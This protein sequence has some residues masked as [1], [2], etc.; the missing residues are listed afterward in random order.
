MWPLDTWGN[1]GHHSPGIILSYWVMEMFMPRRRIHVTERVLL[2]TTGTILSMDQNQWN[3][4]GVHGLINHINPQQVKMRGHQNQQQHFAYLWDILCVRAPC[5]SRQS[6]KEKA[7]HVPRRNASDTC[8]FRATPWPQSYTRHIPSVD[9]PHTSQDLCTCFQNYS[10]MLWFG[11]G[12]FHQC[13]LKLK[14]ISLFK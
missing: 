11:A 2:I 4:P 13:L 8:M 3:N 5:D 1:Y 10:I 7:P 9:R 6:K 14:Q 12:Q